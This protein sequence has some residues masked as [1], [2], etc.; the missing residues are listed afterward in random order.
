MTTI[1]RFARAPLLVAI[2]LLPLFAADG[3]AADRGA[4]NF[5]IDSQR[6]SPRTGV[7]GQCIRTGVSGAGA[8][9]ED[10][11]DPGRSATPAAPSP[12]TP[13]AASAPTPAAPQ[14]AVEE[15]ASSEPTLRHE[16][17]NTPP[18]DDGIVSSRVN[19]DFEAEQAAAKA[20]MAATAPVQ[21]VARITLNAEADLDFNKWEL[22]TAGRAKLD[23]FAAELRTSE[24]GTVRVVG[25]TDR[26]GSQQTNQTLSQ[27]RAHAVKDYLVTKQIDPERIDAEGVGSSQPLTRPQDCQGLK[28]QALI[29][30]LQPDRRVDLDAQATKIVSK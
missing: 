3:R 2:T 27:R 4:H 26:I 18:A 8:P 22:G 15:P 29:S 30:C 9:V 11:N 25:H 6:A 23:Q 28:K 14:V 5:V 13:P 19:A 10:C 20:A 21:R 24:Y 17:E 16:E 12:A 7:L 1:P